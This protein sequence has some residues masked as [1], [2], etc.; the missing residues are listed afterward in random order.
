VKVSTVATAKNKAGEMEDDKNLEAKLFFL[1]K[2]IATNQTK[3][4]II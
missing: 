4:Y 2:I 1:N 3:K